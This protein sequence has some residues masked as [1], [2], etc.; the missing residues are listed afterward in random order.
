MADVGRSGDY[1]SSLG[2][3]VHDAIAVVAGNADAILALQGLAIAV[4]R[5]PFVDIA[6]IYTELDR[7]DEKEQRYIEVANIEGEEWQSL[8]HRY[9]DAIWRSTDSPGQPPLIAPVTAFVLSLITGIELWR[10]ITRDVNTHD[11]YSTSDQSHLLLTVTVASPQKPDAD[12]VRLAFK[13]SRAILALSP[14]SLDVAL[15][16]DKVVRA[17]SWVV[18]LVRGVA[19]RI[20][21]AE[22]AARAFV[23]NVRKARETEN[24]FQLPR[25]DGLS[26]LPWS[27]TAK[28]ANIKGV[29]IFVHGLLSTDLGTFDGFIRRWQKP[30]TDKLPPDYLARDSQLLFKNELPKKAQRALEESVALIGWP[31]DT[32]TSIDQNALDLAGL[33]DGALSRFDYKVAFVCHSR[34]GIVARATAE[35]LYEKNRAWEGRICC[36]ITF[37]SPHA[38]VALA[39][40]PD[41]RLGAYVLAGLTRKELANY[42]DMTAYLE[43]RKRIEGIDDLQPPSAVT[44]P[45]EPYLRTLKALE[46]R[47]A[48]SGGA[49][50]LDIYAVGGVAQLRDKHGPLLERLGRLYD[51]YQSYYTGEKESDLVVPLSSATAANNPAYA[52]SRT[53]CD[54]FS[55]FGDGGADAVWNAIRLLW[56]CFGLEKSIPER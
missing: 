54:H 16:V 43:Q 36:A 11:K 41:R 13:E 40:H 37:G 45:Q 5:T 47:N 25:L 7:F 12:V 29:I 21:S 3:H 31:H 53:T 34:G 27:D 52:P 9:L 46:W 8:V 17:G 23:E 44:D 1:V 49:R 20:R 2:A 26:G 51:R 30:L 55:Y 32:L 10:Q 50:R 18:N 24:V 14:G 48:S 6:D 35:K 4:L 33:V 42:I 22:A 38:G 39:E 19:P 56:Y 15:F 28:V